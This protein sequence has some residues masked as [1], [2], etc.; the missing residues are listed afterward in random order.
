MYIYLF[1]SALLCL[2]V[3]VDKIERESH[4]TTYMCKCNVHI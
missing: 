2:T 3:Q 4:L 1:N